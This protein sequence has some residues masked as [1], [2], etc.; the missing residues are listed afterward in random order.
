MHELVYEFNHAATQEVCPACGVTFDAAIG[1]IPY[2]RTPRVPV[3]GQ[4]ACPSFQYPQAHVELPRKLVVLPIGNHFLQRLLRAC[5]EVGT[6][7]AEQLKTLGE[8]Y[9]EDGP[10]LSRVAV[11]IAYGQDAQARIEP[12]PAEVVLNVN[13]NVAAEIHFWTGAPFGCEQEPESHS[14]VS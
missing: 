5:S 10:L 3:C 4:E 2:L 12:H 1:T 13:A 8:R 6:A 9:P 7:L 11:E 14:T